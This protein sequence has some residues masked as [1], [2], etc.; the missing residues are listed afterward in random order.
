MLSRVCVFGK[1]YKVSQCWR[2]FGVSGG[3][4]Y[5]QYK[6]QPSA[7]RRDIRRLQ[8][9]LPRRAEQ[10]QKDQHA[11]LRR[12]SGVEPAEPC[13]RTAQHPDAVTGLQP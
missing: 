13:E 2:T 6:P 4:L 10:R 9:D 7:Q 3:S 1:K 8:R 5:R 12:L 11:L